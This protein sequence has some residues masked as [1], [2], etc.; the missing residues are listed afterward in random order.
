V[1]SFIYFIRHGRTDQN[2]AGIV[3]NNF[4]DTHGL[5]EQGRKQ[6]NNVREN[7]A[8]S[9]VKIDRVYCSPLRRTQE[10]ARIIVGS[11]TPI[12]IDKR[13]IERDWGEYI[14]KR[15]AACKDGTAGAVDFDIVKI[16][17]F[18]QPQVGRIENLIELEKR[19]FAVIDEIKRKFKGKNI[20]VV[21]HGICCNIAN[22][23]NWGRPES[24]LIIEPK[25]Q[26][27]NCEIVKIKND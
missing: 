6:A 11:E 24:G 22:A 3:A 9:G 12:T 5:N 26:V 27:D 21:S 14:G 4:D 8:K 10:T 2:V 13:L 20:L 23:Y 19:I 17:N 16:C 7:F 25:Y 18:N 15:Y 1:S